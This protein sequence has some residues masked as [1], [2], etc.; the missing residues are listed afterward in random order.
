[1]H[2]KAFILLLFLLLQNILPVNAESQT[3]FHGLRRDSMP[4]LWDEGIPLGNG[5][6]GNLIWEKDGHL[7]MALDHADLWDLRPVK[8]FEESPDYSYS[9]VCNEIVNRKDVEK[10]RRLIDD[11]SRKDC[12]PTK[13]PVGALEF[14]I[15]ALG[16]VKSVEL[17]VHTAVC[18]IVWECGV[19]WAGSLPMQQIEWGTSASKSFRRRL[20]YDWRRPVSKTMEHL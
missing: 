9:F 7:R 2:A 12:A 15:A 16:K 8:E 11:R 5:I 4:T 6:I 19:T 18:T 3:P 20:T 1:M 13:I 14:P 17:D 10:V